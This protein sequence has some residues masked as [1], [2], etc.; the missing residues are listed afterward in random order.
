MAKQERRSQSIL[1]VDG[2][3]LVRH[4]IADYLRDCGYVVVEAAT[5][6]EAK[7]VLAELS[8]G[9]DAVLCEAQA[10]GSLNAFEFRSW[11]TEQ[12]QGLQFALAGN[13][14]AAARKAADLCEQGPELRRPYDP[15][16]LVE[17]VR[18]M[19]GSKSVAAGGGA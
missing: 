3:V 5:T 4:A 7:T 10:P 16:A 1:M 13:V 8:L 12:R 19:L 17:H 11:A 6:D 2:D 9:V 14:E 18:K 15:Q